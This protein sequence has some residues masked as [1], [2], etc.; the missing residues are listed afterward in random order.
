[1]D[2]SAV[3]LDTEVSGGVFSLFVLE[4]SEAFSVLDKA[5]LYAIDLVKFEA[6]SNEIKTYIEYLDLASRAIS[7]DDIL[8][9]RNEF[10][11]ISKVYFIAFAAIVERSCSTV[12]D[13]ELECAKFGGINNF[14]S[15]RSPEEVLNSIARLEKRFIELYVNLPSQVNDE[16]IKEKGL[17][18]DLFI[19]YFNVQRKRCNALMA[20]ISFLM[21]RT[22]DIEHLHH[23]T[24]LR[25]NAE[26]ALIA[27]YE[28]TD[29]TIKDSKRSVQ[30]SIYIAIAIGVAAVVSDWRIYFLNK[31]NTVNVKHVDVS[32][33]PNFRKNS[34]TL[35]DSKGQLLH[36]INS[37]KQQELRRLPVEDALGLDEAMESS[38]H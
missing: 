19:G 15:L 14:K 29:V 36:P 34:S 11:R 3:S 10:L 5:S 31:S 38:N 13:Y 27:S 24:T 26:K 8:A 7:D 35:L 1:M 22:S 25:E 9:L 33:A 21:I 17:D 23:E 2:F 30:K 6:D 18:I 16:S 4:V 37:T 28:H 12:E 20:E 32:E